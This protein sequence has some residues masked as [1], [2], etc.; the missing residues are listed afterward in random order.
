MDDQQACTYDVNYL[1][2]SNSMPAITPAEDHQ[3]Y[4]QTAFV[5]ND[6]NP[7]FAAHDDEGFAEF[8]QEPV[9]VRTGGSIGS[10]RQFC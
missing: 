2:D 10:G 1:E 8:L 7:M 9:E 4:D 5:D 6:G 3:R